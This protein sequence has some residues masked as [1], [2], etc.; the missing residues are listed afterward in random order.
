VN[1]SRYD[2]LHPALVAVLKLSDSPL[3]LRPIDAVWLTSMRHVVSAMCPT[4]SA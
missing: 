3:A 4:V 2:S 1:D